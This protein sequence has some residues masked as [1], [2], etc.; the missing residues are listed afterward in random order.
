MGFSEIRSVGEIIQVVA[1]AKTDISWS[2]EEKRDDIA[3]VSG[4]D[5]MGAEGGGWECGGR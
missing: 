4:E 1:W 2:G 5:S 3:V